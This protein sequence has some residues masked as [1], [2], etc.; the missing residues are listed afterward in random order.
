M[1][2]NLAQAPTGQPLKIKKITQEQLEKNLAAM[3]LFPGSLV[4]V[5][6]E[7][8]SLR[9][10]RVRGPKGEVL[11]SG[12]MGGKIVAHLDDG[13]KVPL[14][15]L[16]PGEQGHI[17]GVTGGRGLTSALSALGLKENDRIEMVRL[18]PP[19]EY[20]TIIEGRGRVRLAEG[21]A[22]KVLGEMMGNEYQF[23]S[24]QVETPFKVTRLI[25]GKRAL[26]AIESLNIKPGLTL[27]LEAVEQA[28]N[29]GNYGL[30][31]IVV[32]S[33]EGL[34]IFLRKDQA[35]MITVSHT[36]KSEETCL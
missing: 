34:R 14:P 2:S 12:G 23:A 24:A 21:M 7:E 25:G 3:G 19:M 5:L 8:I 26:R 10:V 6:D 11:L 16:K 30:D 35:E 9:T 13:R 32:H 31:R 15:E 17:E 22:S 4:T 29:I 27:R 33:S 28:K 18:M 36:D 1:F 20:I